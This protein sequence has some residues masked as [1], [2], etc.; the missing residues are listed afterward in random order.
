MSGKY[1]ACAGALLLGCSGVVL[2]QEAVGTNAYPRGLPPEMGAHDIPAGSELRTLRDRVRDINGVREGL[3]PR[4][5]G[6]AAQLADLTAGSKVFDP[7]GAL[8][9]RLDRL[10]GNRAI[11]VTG[12]G[13]VAVPAE[14]FG[15]NKH[16][17][18][19][20]VSK[21]QFD[22]MVAAAAGTRP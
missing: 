9:G 11:V 3:E 6:S 13:Q 12:T 21:R 20:D 7:E 16:G 8:L 5:K 4:T 14:A 10:D 17:L 15:R 2:A 22:S 19:L 18:L 1:R